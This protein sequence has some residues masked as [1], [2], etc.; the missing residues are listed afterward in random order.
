MHDTSLNLDQFLSQL[1]SQIADSVIVKLGW[2]MPEAEQARDLED[3]P[4][5]AK[6]AGV[7]QQTLQRLRK[8]GKVPCVRMGRRVL[9]RP[10]D[11]LAALSEKQTGGAK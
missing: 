7:S 1:A 6:R 11:V 8:A 2:A 10:A 5:M 3:E 9:Y 4:T